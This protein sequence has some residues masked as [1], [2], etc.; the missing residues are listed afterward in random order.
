MLR[1]RIKEV[2]FI[3]PFE[4]AASVLS[5][6]IWCK[7][8]QRKRY[9]RATSI[10]DPDVQDRRAAVRIPGG[11]RL[12]SYANLYFDARNSM[13]SALRHLND[14]IAVV[15]VSHAVID[16]PDVIVSDRNA[17]ADDVIF[18]PA[19]KGIAALNRNEVYAEWWNMSRDAKQKR[20]AEVLVPRR[21]PPSTSKALMSVRRRAKHNLPNFAQLD[22]T[23]LS[24]RTDTSERGG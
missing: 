13:M 6:G 22:S 16:L 2:H 9:P 7:I 11:G 18:R 21:V 1:G 24:T 5:D 17:A 14:T 20:C 3:C 4:S 23:S 12:H 15:R 10:A 8:E 19:A